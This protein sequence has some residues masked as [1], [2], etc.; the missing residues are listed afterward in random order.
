MGWGHGSFVSTTT[1]CHRA[2]RALARATPLVTQMH[3]RT[4][5]AQ[6]MLAAAAMRQKQLLRALRPRANIILIL[7]LLKLRVQLK[8]LNLVTLRS[9]TL[10]LRLLLLRPTM[11][12]TTLLL[13]QR[14]GTHPSQAQL[15]PR[16]Q[17]QLIALALALALALTLVPALALTLALALALARA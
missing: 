9:Q 15:R 10:L 17:P 3:T 2:T 6:H 16:T 4:T 8:V 1:R 12:L 7:Q 11:H 14:A 5:Q 13:L